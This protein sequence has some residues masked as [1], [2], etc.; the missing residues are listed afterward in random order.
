MSASE[1]AS[2]SRLLSRWVVPVRFA[3][4]S[5]GSAF[6][7][8]AASTSADALEFHHPAETLET[9]EVS[10]ARAC[11]EHA[12]EVDCRGDLR[13][14]A[15]PEVF[16]VGADADVV[17]AA[18]APWSWHDPQAAGARRDGQRLALR[19]FG[20]LQGLQRRARGSEVC[21]RVGEVTQVVLPQRGDN[22]ETTRQLAASVYD[23]GEAADHDVADAVAFERLEQRVRIETHPLAHSSP[24]CFKRL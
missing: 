24:S 23:P 10:R 15:L 7:V 20:G 5:S 22:V 19:Q 2:V 3:S 1:D 11:F 4:K 6:D 16:A 8:E 13:T 21:E 18:G 9:F 17:V 12:D 14:Q